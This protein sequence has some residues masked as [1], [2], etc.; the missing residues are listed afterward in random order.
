MLRFRHAANRVS[1]LMKKKMSVTDSS[2]SSSQHDMRA[3]SGAKRPHFPF[4]GKPRIDVDLEDP[5]IPLLYFEFYTP[6][7]AEIIAKESDIP[8][9]IY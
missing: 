4:T 9:K 2:S 5:S 8:P 7:I 3:T 6:G 1:A